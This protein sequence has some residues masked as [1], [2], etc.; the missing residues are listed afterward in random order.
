MSC[1]RGGSRAFTLIELLVVIAI[2]AVLIALLLPAV[3]SAREA[4]RRAQ[5]VNNLK[6]LG[7]AVHNYLS[8][9]NVFPAQSIQN[10]AAWGWIPSW[11]AAVLPML[12][13][14]PLYNAINFSI[15]MY[16]IGFVS[17]VYG[18]NTTVALTTVASLVCPSESMLHGTPSIAGDF[19]M[20]NYAGN[21]GGPGMIASTSGTIVPPRGSLW[22][23]GPNL[24]PVT[25][26]AV[27]D[28]TTN[29]ALFSEHLLAF[30]SNVVTS[31]PSPLAAVGSA[32]QKRSLFQTSVALNVDQGANAL[33]QAQAFVAAC[34]SLPGGTLP[35]SDD[36]FGSQ[37]LLNQEYTTAN[38]SYSHVMTPNSLSCA[39]PETALFGGFLSDSQWGGIAAAIT[40]TSNHPAGVNVGLADGSVRF[41]KDSINILTWWALGSRSLGEIISADQY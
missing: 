34:K 25:I 18:G 3:Q 21:F 20:S 26:A 11:T 32:N 27:T 6:Q 10:T 23:S 41:M 15:P 30:G 1:R 5:C 2:I 29:T 14:Q 12:E 33:A 7:L 19:A 37:W 17:P 28:G 36:A 9:N 35:S 13:Q 40:A 24:G 22:F 4:A 31:G 8:Q 39:G 16:E 38:V